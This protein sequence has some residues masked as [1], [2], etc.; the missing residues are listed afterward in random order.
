MI[1]RSGYLGG[2]NFNLEGTLEEVTGETKLGA[3]P[4][5]ATALIAIHRGDYSNDDAP[6][7]YGKVH[8]SARIVSHEDLYGTC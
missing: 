4:G 2:Q 1:V 5:N 3:L 6:F 8:K 7:Y